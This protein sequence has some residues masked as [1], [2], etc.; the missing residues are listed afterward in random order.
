VEASEIVDY[1]R[2]LVAGNPSLG[3]HITL[4]KGKIK[5]VELPEKVDILISEPMGTLLLNERMIELYVM[6]RDMFLSPI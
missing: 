1:A 6:A 2:R 5:E 4:I 3:Q